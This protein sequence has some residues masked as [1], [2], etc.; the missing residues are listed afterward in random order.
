M[1]TLTEETIY[2]GD[3][4][5]FIRQIVS[6]VL[7]PAS[8]LSFCFFGPI[9]LE[10]FALFC[11]VSA[12]VVG[13]FYLFVKF[14]DRLSLD[15][16]T[17]EVHLALRRLP[18][19]SITSFR[20]VVIGDLAQISVAPHW[21]NNTPLLA[22]LSREKN[23]ALLRSLKSRCPKARVR[24]TIL[25]RRVTI[26]L[27]LAA[28]S[29]LYM[30]FHFFVMRGSSEAG[31]VCE[32]ENWY[33]EDGALT[34][35]AARKLG[36]IEFSVPAGFEPSDNASLEG[37]F[38]FTSMDPPANLSGVWRCICQSKQAR[39]WSETQRLAAQQ[40]RS[41]YRLRLLPMGVLFSV[42]RAPLAAEV[43]A[44]GTVLRPSG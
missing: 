19:E 41:R 39:S 3:A 28:I 4:A 13:L 5:G 27:P 22:A 1:Q 44:L 31:A 6:H 16:D 36:A 23:E 30:G 24:E 35:G 25:S 32:V 37:D 7:P 14:W 38:W 8:L 12:P 21:W 20:V 15:D 42:R 43:T 9:G 33:R 26:G 34:Y 18:Y 2:R 40:C 10:V 29:L 17:G 11:L